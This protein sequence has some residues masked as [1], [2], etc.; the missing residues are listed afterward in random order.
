MT[1]CPACRGAYKF[2]F[3]NLTLTR[4]SY[5]IY[6]FHITLYAVYICV[7]SMLN[8]RWQFSVTCL[9]EY[10]VLTT[11]AE[12]FAKHPSA[13]IRINKQF[14]AS[15][16]IYLINNVNH[17]WLTEITYSFNEHKMDEAFFDEINECLWG[18][19]TCWNIGNRRH[20]YTHL[21][22]YDPSLDFQQRH[23]H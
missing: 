11:Y 14:M 7:G 13:K 5:H 6:N 3:C 21:M 2:I 19:V 18:F 22:S 4:K 16:H 20:I 12:K 9:V 15:T 10:L 17:F 8:C 23:K 1:V